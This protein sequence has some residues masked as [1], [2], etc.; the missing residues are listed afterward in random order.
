MADKLLKA[1]ELAEVLGVK[2]ETVRRWT[3]E[4]RIPEIR[5]SCKVRRFDL[6][7]VLMVFKKERPCDEGRQ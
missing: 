7:Q 2:P 6:A 4:G 3:R 1:S 5:L